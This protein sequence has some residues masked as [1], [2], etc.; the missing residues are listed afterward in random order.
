MEKIVILDSLVTNPEND[1]WGNLGSLGELIV[2]DR[3]EASD[4]IARATEAKYIIT[5]K[6]IIDD[7]VMASLPN[8]KYI[9][10]MSTGTNAADLESAKKRG[11]IVTNIPAYS[12]DSVA[13]LIFSFI[14]NMSYRVVEHNSRV[15]NGQ[16]VNS[17]DFCFYDRNVNEI[18]G[19]TLGL[20]GFGSIGSRVAEI[21]TIFGMN[22][23]VYSRTKKDTSANKNITWVSKEEVFKQSDYLALACPL[24]DETENI[25][26]KDTLTL[27][28]KT[29]CLI[30][31]SRGGCVVEADLA[32][33][34]NSDFIAY[35]SVDVLSTEPPKHDNPLLSAKNCIITPH[36]A[37][38]TREA[39]ERLA[40]VLYDNLKCFMDGNPQNV[41]NK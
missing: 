1:L 15:H 40:S 18:K 39:R 19:K 28:K 4:T 35:A 21:A 12:T 34:L 7:N 5:N 22:I 13:Q 32:Q 23:V 26:N 41:V 20:I 24:T 38:T 36:I 27:M 2:Y 10:L 25:I 16:W 31:T 37:W 8:L 14:L 6:T 3:T 33:A 30:N 17:V 11:V 9:G 29:A